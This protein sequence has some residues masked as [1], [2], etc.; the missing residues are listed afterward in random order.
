MHWIAK[1][2]EEICLYSVNTK[3]FWIYIL[4]TEKKTRLFAWKYNNNG[5]NFYIC[6]SCKLH[7]MKL[8]I[9]LCWYLSHQLYLCHL[10]IIWI[11]ILNIFAHMIVQQ[12]LCNLIL[13]WQPQVSLLPVLHN[14]SNY[15]VKIQNNRIPWEQFITV[16]LRSYIKLFNWRQMT[17]V[18]STPFCIMVT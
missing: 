15:T 16:M 10:K 4:S 5:A 9:H 14:P 1:I 18:T 7:S 6:D 17:L 2:L 8:L 12:N 3:L 11:A 13:C